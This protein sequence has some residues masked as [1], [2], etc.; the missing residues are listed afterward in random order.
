MNFGGLK[1]NLIIETLRAVSYALISPTLSL[2]LIVVGILFY[3][4]NRKIAFMQKLML[5][6]SISSPLELTLSQILVGIIGGII[7]SLML[8]FLGV[9][10]EN[11]TLVDVILTGTLFFIIYRNRFI[12]MPYIATAIGIIGILLG[13]AEEY[14]GRGFNFDSN[15]TSIIALVG[16]FSI[17]EGI[18]TMM[19]GTKGY[20]PIFTQK[21][22]KLIGG[23]SFR[24][25][26]II[27]MGIIVI[28]GR[29]SGNTI[30]SEVR[31]L[32]NWLPF[33]GVE[34]ISSV[35]SGLAMAT[36]AAYGII[37]YDSSTFTRSKGNKIVSSA[38]IDIIY[39]IVILGLD[40][41]FTYS[42]ILTIIL[43]ILNPFL[44]ALRIKFE[45]KIESKRRPLY[46]SNNDDI[47]I[48]DVLPD[49]LAFEE[50]LRSGDRII[51]V[52][53]ETPKSEKDVF[54]AMKK[55]Y[56]GVNLEV[57]KK[58]GNIK[59]YSIPS[60]SRGTLF[61]VVLVPKGTSFDKEVNEF[62]EK[63]KKASK[64]EIN[65]DK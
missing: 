34:N 16:V 12:K 38:L 29:N 6:R 18:L 20:L 39:G 2:M 36:I 51:K 63:L 35:I 54:M 11:S 41:I 7:A 4:K 30:I 52:N 37:S 64:E 19:D 27:P 14:L 48:L 1:V 23:F 3:F 10:F 15:I 44:Y 26:W 46:F 47:C 43:L 33:L 13:F 21:E 25:F 17:T 59:K 22:G 56:Y 57:R 45:E 28:M 40:Y 31:M 24:R 61:G 53:D 50:G 49:S 55:N 62:I 9:T 60:E 32:P 65:N 58:D 8:S 5:G 42:Y